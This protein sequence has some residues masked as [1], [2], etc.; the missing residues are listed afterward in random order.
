[1]IVKLRPSRLEP[2]FDARPWGVNSLAPLFPEQNNLKEK[3][4]EAW[5]T[6]EKCRFAD[7]P[8]AGSTLGEAWLRMPVEW[9]GTKLRP[10]GAFPILVKFIF[11]DDRLSVQ[12]HPDDEYASQHEKQAGGNGKTEMW[13]FVSARPRGEILFGLK[14]GVERDSVRRAIDDATVENFV[15]RVSA[16][17]GD[18]IFV[19]SGTVHAI[20]AGFVLCE[21]QQQSDITYRVY[22]YNRRNAAGET[23]ALHVEK[24]MDVIRFGEQKGGKIEPVTIERGPLSETY[25]AAC[26]YF[27]AERWEFS[28]SIPRKTS[29]EHF[30]L[31]ISI[32]GHGVIEANGEK[33]AYAPA[34]VWLI[35]AGLGAYQIAPQERTELLRTYVPGNLDEYA[36]LLGER[37]V[38]ESQLAHLVHK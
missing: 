5:L 34:Q 27:A 28:E 1:M 37:G 11:T 9:T 13:Y 22:D 32:S 7:G 8:F 31:L 3:I 2:I 15:V 14:P 35:P 29:P 10:A 4:G 12:V 16:N 18:A 33:I 23:R 25:L 21:I 26:R 17:A 30:D 20:G 36:R 6:G 19:P 24:A 38:S